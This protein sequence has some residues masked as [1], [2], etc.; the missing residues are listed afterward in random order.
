MKM[1]IINKSISI[2][3]LVSLL[4][5]HA[6]IRKIFGSSSLLAL[7]RLHKQQIKVQAGRTLLF[8]ACLLNR[9]CSHNRETRVHSEGK[10]LDHMLNKPYVQP[11]PLAIKWLPNNPYVI[12]VNLTKQNPL[13]K[14]CQ[15][16]ETYHTL[17]KGLDLLVLK[18]LGLQVKGSQSYQLSML[19]F[20]KKSLPLQPFHPNCVQSHSARV[21]SRAK[22][23][24]FQS[25][26]A[27]NFKAL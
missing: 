20:S 12:E 19:E 1:E 13:L 6:R 3:T 2:Y 25:L 18:I 14:Y 9:A 4:H 17:K 10:I 21:R 26:T 24:H 23:N 5:D 7:K 8:S 16:L 15:H 22:S 27:R 11:W